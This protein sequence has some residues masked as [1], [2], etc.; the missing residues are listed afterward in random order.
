MAQ[1]FGILLA[2]AAAGSASSENA[3][4]KGYD[5]VIWFFAGLN[6][7]GIL[8][9][10]FLPNLDKFKELSDEE[11]K[12]KQKKGDVTGGV[13]AVISVILM[14]ILLVINIK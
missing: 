13:L 4:K 8:I 11:R 2:L 3:K 12:S 1:W 6:I 10:M 9:I 5:P 7:F 14:I